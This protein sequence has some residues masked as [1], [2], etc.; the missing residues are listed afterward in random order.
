MVQY[1][2]DESMGDVLT[3]MEMEETDDHDMLKSTLFTI[4]SETRST[5]HYL[6][7]SHNDENE[8][9]CNV[10]YRMRFHVNIL[11]RNTALALSVIAIWGLLF[12]VK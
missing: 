2:M 4:F 9:M 11:L 8:C 1:H 7:N 5:Y 3:A 6:T 12:N 10:K